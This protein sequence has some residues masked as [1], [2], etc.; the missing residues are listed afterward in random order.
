MAAGAR[1]NAMEDKIDHHNFEKN[2]K[3]GTILPRKLILAI[4]ERDRRV[5]AFKEVRKQWQQKINAWKEDRTKPNP[6]LIAGGRDGKPS[7]AAIHLLLT[8]DEAQEESTGEAKLHGSSVT[9]FI[10]AGLQLEEAQQRIKREAHGRT[11]LQAD[12]QQRVQDMHVAFFSKLGRWRKLQAVYMSSAVRQ[13]EEE[14][15]TRDPKLPPPSAEDVKLYLPSGLRQADRADGYYKGLPVMEGKLREGQLRDSL[16]VLRSRL[17][18][19]RHLLNYRD[20]S[21][22]GQWAAMQAYTLIG[23]IEE[24]VDAMSTKYRRS[25][26]ALIALRG[27]VAC[28]KFHKLKSSDV[29][30][31]EECEVDIKARKK[32]GNMGSKFRRQGPALSSKNKTFSWIWTGGGGPGEDEVELHESVRVEWSKA[33]ARNQRWEEEV[34]LLR[35]E[36]KRVLRFLRWRSVSRELASGIEAYTARQAALHRDIS[37]KFKT[38]WDTSAATAVRL[39]VRENTLFMEGNTF[40]RMESSAGLSGNAGEGEAGS[41]GNAGKGGGKG[42]GNAGGG[43]E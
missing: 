19:K 1:H 34:E 37:R 41:S 17:H 8:Q 23:R 14:E 43:T 42:A 27:S 15:G 40:E 25:R 10:V 21:V 32:L 36:M 5:E 11:L 13:L 35:E 22:V 16:R 7:G 31:D 12:Q 26:S 30:L 20:K 4:N 28:E 9:S 18:A 2:I 38:A 39:A 3:Q 6:Y 33:K 24:R 29:Q